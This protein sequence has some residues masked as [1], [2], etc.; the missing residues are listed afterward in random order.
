MRLPVPLHAG[1]F[2]TVSQAGAVFGPALANKGDKPAVDL[3]GRAAALLPVEDE[4]RPDTVNKFGV[5]PRSRHD[6]QG[7]YTGLP[8]G[9][10]SGWGRH[11]KGGVLSL[12]PPPGVQHMLSESV[13]P[14]VI[15]GAAV[16]GLQ[17]L[18]GK[19]SGYAVVNGQKIEHAGIW[20]PRSCLLS[21]PL[22]GFNAWCCPALG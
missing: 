7:V 22:S 6:F 16:E 1:R 5:Y 2:G 21:R 11:F 8:V 12:L 15:V 14:R 3:F 13:V 18:A 9:V 19:R 10:K 4:F 20:L 17:L